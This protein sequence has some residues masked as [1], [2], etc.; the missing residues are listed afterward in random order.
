MEY[1]CF[2][3][4]NNV[5][6]RCCLPCRKQLLFQGQI[7]SLELDNPYPAQGVN[8]S[9]KNVAV[10][11]IYLLK[12]RSNFHKALLY[13]LSPALL[14]RPPPI[15]MLP[16]GTFIPPPG[17][18]MPG[19]IYCTEPNRHFYASSIFDDLKKNCKNCGPKVGMESIF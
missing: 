18:F 10:L 3:E 13:R 12:N 1:Y 15:F 8:F 11:G 5:L 4:K 6:P 17:I 16:P 14:C 7:L 19:G 2:A 9:D